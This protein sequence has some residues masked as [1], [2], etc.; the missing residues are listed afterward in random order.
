[1]TPEEV[2][3]AAEKRGPKFTYAVG[4]LAELLIGMSAEDEETRDSVQTVLDYM[5]D[6]FG[7]PKEFWHEVAAFVRRAAREIE[8]E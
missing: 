7:E 1:M 2:A 4:A 6:L 5:I 3:A 8:D